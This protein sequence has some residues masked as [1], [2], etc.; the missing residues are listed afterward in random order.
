MN[1]HLD[2]ALAWE[3]FPVGP[4]NSPICQVSLCEV[5]VVAWPSLSHNVACLLVESRTLTE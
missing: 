4:N 3:N 2:Q 1:Y 5:N